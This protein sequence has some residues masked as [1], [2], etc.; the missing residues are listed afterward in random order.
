MIWCDCSGGAHIPD[1]RLERG[2]GG[3]EKHPLHYVGP[4]RAAEFARRLEHLLHQHRVCHPGGG[5]DG[6]RAA[7]RDQGGAVPDAGARGAL[8]GRRA[9]V[10]QQAG[11]QGL[12]ERCRDQQATRPHLRQEEPVAHP[13]LLCPHRRRVSWFKIIHTR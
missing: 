10:C 6:P 4:R 2:G 13:V 11:P 8:V 7:G 3:V 5:L 9:R 12:D 1:D